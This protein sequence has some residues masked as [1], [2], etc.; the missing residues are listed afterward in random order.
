MSNMTKQTIDFIEMLDNKLPAIQLPGQFFTRERISNNQLFGALTT[1]ARGV[2]PNAVIGLTDPTDDFSGKEGVL[3]STSAIYFSDADLSNGKHGNTMIMYRDIKDVVFSGALLNAA[4]EL[5]VRNLPF[6]SITIRDMTL[7]MQPFVDVIK[8][9]IE[10]VNDG[11]E[12]ESDRKESIVSIRYY[13]KKREH[14]MASVYRSILSNT[15]FPKEYCSCM[16][17]LGLTPLHYCLL[18]RN[19]DMALSIAKESLKFFKDIYLDQQPTSLYNYCFLAAYRDLRDAFVSIYECSTAMKPIMEQRKKQEIKQGIIKA[20]DLG[21]DFIPGSGLI[22]VGKKG[23]KLLSKGLEFAGSSVGQAGIDIVRTKIEND[24]VNSLYE[25]DLTHEMWF[26][27]KEG[28]S[29]L[30]NEVPEYEDPRYRILYGLYTVK[31]ALHRRVEAE[32]KTLICWNKR[33]LAITDY[34]IVD[35]PIWSEYVVGE[36]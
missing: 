1:Y 27:C 23:G 8:C 21:I 26:K 31:E 2:N 24:S 36:V 16:D 33:Y 4:L 9:I 6:D 5:K 32:N 25:D 29:E 11:Y 34:E 12:F 13:M 22:K 14:I 15:E 10:L 18:L 17:G 28:I 3:F 30:C 20:V 35:D 7:N 19:E